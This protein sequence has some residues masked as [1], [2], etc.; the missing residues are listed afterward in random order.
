MSNQAKKNFLKGLGKSGINTSFSKIDH[1]ASFGNMALNYIVTGSLKAGLPN[2]RTGAIAGPSGSGK[3]F[4]FGNIIRNLQKDGYMIVYVDTENAIDDEFLT[5][6]G[7][8]LDEEVFIP[9]TI[10]TIEELTSVTS[11]IFKE[12]EKDEKIAV[13]VDSMSN[14]ITEQEQE[15]FEKSN[16]ANSFGLLPKKIKQLVKNVNSKIGE[17]DMYFIYNLHTYMNQDMLNGEGKYM[18]SGGTAQLFLPSWALMLDKLNLKDGGEQIGIRMK[19]T[20]KKTRYNQLGLKTDI[21]IP[22]DKGLDELFGVPEILERNGVVSKSGA[23]YS[24][25]NEEGET[26]KFQKKTFEEHADYLIEKFEE[27]NDKGEIEESMDSDSEE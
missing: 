15:A 23:W 4:I 9:V 16:L 27:M 20:T 10:S 17:R 8:S 3:S 14:L 26:V 1:W 6:L 11:G 22:W 2:R 5:K 25:E 21:H 18:V 24:Y 12:F 19:A 13:M 7:V